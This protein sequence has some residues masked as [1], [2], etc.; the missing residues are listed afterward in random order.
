MAT[1]N[2]TVRVQEVNG[3]QIGGCQIQAQDNLGGTLSSETGELTGTTNGSILNVTVNH[4]RFAKE[5]IRIVLA[6][7]AWDL[8][9]AQVKVTPDGVT[10]VVTLI[11]V[12][13]MRRFV[14]DEKRL[15]LEKAAPDARDAE[16]ANVAKRNAA[17]LKQLNAEVNGVLSG[18]GPDGKS[19]YLWMGDEV[20]EFTSTEL[21]P[22]PVLTSSDREGW[23]RFRTQATKID[24]HARG[25]FLL[26]QYGGVF[27]D[28]LAS[29]DKTDLPQ[30]VAVYIPDLDAGSV[31]SERDV[32]L[33]LPP[34]TAKPEYSVD[35]PFGLN[36]SGDRIEQPF[37]A[38]LGVGYMFSRHYLIHQLL[39]NNRK[40]LLVLPVWRQDGPG[41]LLDPKAMLR[42]VRE[43]VAFAHKR[44]FIGIRQAKPF[45]VAEQPAAPKVGN[46]TVAAFSAGGEYLKA[47]L[48]EQTGGQV[49]A[50]RSIPT[51]DP[52]RLSQHWREAI[53]LDANASE[54]FDIA[55]AQWKGRD[56]R[57]GVRIASS[58]YTGRTSA[59]LFRTGT[60]SLPL[61]GR[62]VTG[63][64]R[65]AS[66]S[67]VPAAAVE[68]Y[69]TNGG[70]SALITTQP[71]LQPQANGQIPIFSWSSDPHQFTPNFGLAWAIAN[72]RLR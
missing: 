8:P 36:I 45:I 42:L 6:A 2:V 56:E 41:D 35:Y 47:L 58:G 61:L 34:N 62:F 50:L 65:R 40:A 4:P 11:R 46:L 28:A 43:M 14:I 38:K 3:N 33:F 54:A 64:V 23:A 32:V 48:S 22:G 69:A 51:A 18:S 57:R 52:A 12:T 72:S 15:Q 17:N 13:E 16:K 9:T 27:A 21:N 5:A 25:Q 37:I 29:V 1:R 70:F 63:P 26:V 67:P 31:I 44:Q 59:D 60:S 66:G 53:D 49:A 20:V 19:R 55:L 24:V 68:T 10:V 39:A 71:Y 30:L 7:P